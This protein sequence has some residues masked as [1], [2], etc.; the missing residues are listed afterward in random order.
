[1]I[2]RFLALVLTAAA[3]V[4]PAATAAPAS[5]IISLSPTAT[6]DLFAIGAGPHVVA[7]D[8]QSNY[9]KA[10]PH[11][12]LSGYT[13]N[14]EAVAAY[15][16]DLVVVSYDANHIVAAL[17]KL[18]I[19]VLIQPTAPTLAEAYRQILELGKAT[20]RTAS[21][22]AVVSRMKKQIAAIAASAAHPASPITVYH[23]LEPDLY[24]ATSKTFI[25]RLYALLGLKNIADAADKTGSGYPKLS[26]E[27]VIASKPQLIV[28]A[29]TV[30]CSQT[31]STLGSRPG[32]G[33]IPAVTGNGV[34]P[35]SDDIASRWGP[36]VVDFLR[37]VAARAK[38]L[39]AK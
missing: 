16:P 21:A 27:Y 15:H 26:A 32:W 13:P 33:T 28:L 1:L 39:A 30:C 2:A 3:L 9:P 35:V 18:G 17:G 4:A 12:K 23:E 14:A 31:A 29:D 22:Q 10:A 36:R 7:V 8:D 38:E 5:R 19:K 24:S 20:G 37:V 6:E 25:G 11:S 34:L